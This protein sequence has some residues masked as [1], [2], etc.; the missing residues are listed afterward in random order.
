LITLFSSGSFFDSTPCG[1]SFA[2]FAQSDRPLMS[3]EEK[4]R[5]IETNIQYFKEEE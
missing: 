4:G 2:E 5:R 1:A 3:E